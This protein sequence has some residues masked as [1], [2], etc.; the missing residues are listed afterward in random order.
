MRFLKVNKKKREKIFHFSLFVKA[1]RL[2]PQCLDY[3]FEPSFLQIFEA[4]SKFCF[5]KTSQRSYFHVFHI[6]EYIFDIN[7]ECMVDVHSFQVVFIISLHIN[8]S[9]YMVAGSNKDM[10]CYLYHILYSLI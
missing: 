9:L 3:V 10:I 1:L 8:S 7:Y 4:F 5:L 2:E 6:G